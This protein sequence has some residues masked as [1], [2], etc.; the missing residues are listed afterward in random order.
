MIYVFG[1]HTNATPQGAA[2]LS[3]LHVHDGKPWQGVGVNVV[4]VCRPAHSSCMNLFVQLFCVGEPSERQHESYPFI[5]CSRREFAG[6][7]S[8]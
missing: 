7:C 4:E 8:T 2:H 6:T 5:A 1:P 3:G